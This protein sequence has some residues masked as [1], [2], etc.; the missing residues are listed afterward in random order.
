MVADTSLENC[1]YK[2]D[3]KPEVTVT[4][5]RWSAFVLCLSLLLGV[6]VFGTACLFY[7]FSKE[8]KETQNLARLEDYQLR[9][10]NYLAEP[11][12]TE[13]ELNG[14]ID[15]EFWLQEL[16]V[17]LDKR[18]KSDIRNTVYHEFA[19]QNVSLFAYDRPAIHLKPQKNRGQLRSRLDNDFPYFKQADGRDVILW[20]NS[21]ELT[22]QQGLMDYRDGE[23]IVL[24]DGLYFIYSQIYFWTTPQV[25]EFQQQ[26]F[27]QYVYRKTSYHDPI[28]LSKA[29]VT[30]CWHEA[31]EFDLFS[32]YQ[33]ALFELTQGD[34]IFLKVT[35]V[36]AVSL[37][38]ESTYFGAF[39]VY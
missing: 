39:M 11:N 24:R 37:N 33:G 9:C 6:E 1:Y 26:P 17:T 8:I 31:A 27:L 21:E 34:R 12:F 19:V 3:E 25:K 23:I 13:Q 2:L 28:L 32:S 18:L 14:D 30:K 22:F 38:E 15:C 5:G 35:D 29:V 4:N 20:E 16:N 10:I 36:T 7:S